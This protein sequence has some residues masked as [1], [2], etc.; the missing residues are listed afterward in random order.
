MG[1]GA[2]WLAS[3]KAPWS[4]AELSDPTGRSGNWLGVE[5]DFRVRYRIMDRVQLE[6]SYS[7]FNPGTFSKDQGKGLS[8]NFFY[9]AVTVSPFPVKF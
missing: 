2:F 5:Y 9:L 3:A 4:R 6:S 8:S 1:Y 7:R